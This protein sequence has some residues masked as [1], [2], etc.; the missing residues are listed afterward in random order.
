MSQKILELKGSD[1]VKGKSNSPYLPTGGLLQTLKGVNPFELPGTAL[2]ALNPSE[3]TTGTVPKIFNSW[4]DGTTAYVYVHT[5]TKLYRVLKDSPYT[6]TDVTSEIVTHT[7]I[8]GATI[9]KGKYIYANIKGTPDLRSNSLP[10]AAGSD[11]VILAGFQN[12]IDYMAMCVGADS[13]LYIGDDFRVG[14]ITS[15]TGTTGNSNFFTLEDGFHVRDLINDGRYLVILSDNNDK[16]LS[17]LKVGNYRCKVQFWDMIKSTADISFDVDDSYLIAGKTIDNSVY[18]F[19]Y[20]GLYVCNSATQPSLIRDFGTNT[21]SVAKPYSPYHLTK[22][23]G[24]LYWVYGGTDT[25]YQDRVFAYG[26]PISG[27]R[28]IFY[29]PFLIGYSSVVKGMAVIG[30]QFWVGLTNLKTLVFNTGS[31]RGQADIRPLN[32]VMDKPHRYDYTK[33]TLTSPLTSGQSVQ[34]LASSY[35]LATTYS[36]ETKSY[37]ATN[38][39]QT[40]LFRP[41]KAG[42]HRD[43]FED[44][45]LYIT[46]SGGANI[47]RVSVYATPLDDTSEDI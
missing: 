37:S 40:L 28:K 34:L 26:N 33:I 8:I 35:S 43:K 42:T 20:N 39:K 1:W 4:T 11:T 25:A 23:R 32:L 7:D 14:I 29:D 18:F 31:T 21:I 27:Q 16:S 45:Q 36:V 22:S 15:S 44:L 41:V 10:V 9:W 3:I 6:V 24:S 5:P 17:K 2:P 30:E 19:G 46:A 38:P 13:N 12:T 47:Q